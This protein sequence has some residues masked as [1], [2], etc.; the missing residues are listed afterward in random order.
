MSN[1]TLHDKSV[2]DVR[3]TPRYLE[4]MA[5]LLRTLDHRYRESWVPGRTPGLTD[6]KLIWNEVMTRYEAVVKAGDELGR[7]RIIKE[8]D[9]EAPKE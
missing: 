7:G 2:P 3:P 9:A 6:A 1:P 4:V 8:P 5:E